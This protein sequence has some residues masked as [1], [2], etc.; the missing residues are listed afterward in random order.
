MVV[1]LPVIALAPSRT[2]RQPPVPRARVCRALGRGSG[3]GPMLDPAGRVVMGRNF[4]T[5]LR[6]SGALRR[7][8]GG[9]RWR[10]PRVDSGR[11]SLERMLD[12]WRLAVRGLMK[13]RAAISRSVRRW[14]RRA[15]T[16]RS[17][18][19]RS[20]PAS[21]AAGNG[22]GWRPG[23]RGIGAG[24]GSGAC[25]ACQ[26]SATRAAPSTGSATWRASATACSTVRPAP[27]RRLAAQRG[28]VELIVQASEAPLDDVAV[29]RCRDAGRGGAG[30]DGLGG[31][32]QVRRGDRLIRDGGDGGQPAQGAGER[33][34]HHAHPSSRPPTRPGLP[35]PCPG[36]GADLDDADLAQH[37]AESPA[38]AGRPQEWDGRREARDRR[39]LITS[40]SGDYSLKAELSPHEQG[41][42]GRVGRVDGARCRSASSNNAI[43]RA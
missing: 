7:G 10:R 12:T 4:S 17:R 29:A 13:S 20:A 2:V 15:K 8:R 33:H 37:H 34:D 43:A 42:M 35:P 3:P 39:G 24:P 40:A 22:T 32:Q 41:G 6:I 1:V 23:G 21:N 30:I 25:V 5:Q 16:S 31:T 9:R 28:C 27:A 19:V 38:A 11:L 26:I 18:R 14:Q 36:A